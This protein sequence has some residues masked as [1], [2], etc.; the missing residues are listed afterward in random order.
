[1]T[2]D[3]TFNVIGAPMRAASG[4]LTAGEIVFFRPHGTELAKF[5]SA[6]VHLHITTIT[7]PDGDDEI[8]FFLQTAYD[9]KGQPFVDTG[10]NLPE[11]VGGGP[12]SGFTPNQNQ[13]M[14][15]GAIGAEAGDLIRVDNE[16]MF[17]MSNTGAETADF[18]RVLRGSE[19]DA[20]VAHLAAADIFRQALTWE[21]VANVHFAVGDN[22]TTAEAFIAIGEM[23]A[24]VAVFTHSDLALADD[25]NRD[26]PL[27]D[28]LRLVTVLNG[29][30]AP[31]YAYSAYVSLYGGV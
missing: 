17:V 25:T 20:V 18:T 9:S 26:L 30:T 31:T 8:D 19:G 1:M 11:A 2:R 28:R 15:T 14:H 22:G 5:M 7:T 24:G 29:A 4:A 6:L 21:D 12:T 3:S 13:L 10:V 16:R 23:A 27:G